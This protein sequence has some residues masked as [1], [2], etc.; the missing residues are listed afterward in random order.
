MARQPRDSQRQKVYDTELKVVGHEYPITPPEAVDLVRRIWTRFG[1][2]PVPRI[3]FY[4][5]RKRWVRSYYDSY[6]HELNIGIQKDEMVSSLS[7]AHETVHA[8]AH[9]YKASGP[10]A[11]EDSDASH[12]PRFTQIAMHVYHWCF[13][14]A[15]SEFRREAAKLR[16]KIAPRRDFDFMKQVTS[17]R[18]RRNRH[19]HPAVARMGREYT[20]DRDRIKRELRRHLKS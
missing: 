16:A 13:G 2:N 10:W 4:Q 9:V 3:K 19:F 6:E 17:A 8:L 18:R 15:P 11:R 5:G 14:V 1:F 7:A 20:A 12:G